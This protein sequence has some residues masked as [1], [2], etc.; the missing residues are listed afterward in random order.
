M[1][2]CQSAGWTA[3]GHFWL[4]SNLPH[5]GARPHLR[6][7]DPPQP[8]GCVHPYA[9]EGNGWRRPG[10]PAVS[11]AVASPSRGL[12]GATALQEEP[13]CARLG[14]GGGAPGEPSPGSG[15][16]NGPTGWVGGTEKKALLLGA[17]RGGGAS[18]PKFACL[19]FSILPIDSGENVA[20]LF[21]NV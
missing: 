4:T 18:T 16:P 6:N 17:L 11:R 10:R 8:E 21:L 3:F 14:G 1:V 12:R 13:I 20:A 7:N 2:C 15:R 9:S 19:C 5:R